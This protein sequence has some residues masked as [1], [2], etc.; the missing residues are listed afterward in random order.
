MPSE[1]KRQQH[2][3]GLE[4]AKQ[5]KTGHNDT[6]MSEQ[7]LKEF[8]ATKTNGLPNRVKPKRKKKS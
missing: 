7:Q 8:A 3:M 4:L 2:F 5:R 6:S 1:S